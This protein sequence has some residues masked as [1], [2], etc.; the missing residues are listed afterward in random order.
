VCDE[1]PCL[2]PSTALREWQRLP[3]GLLEAVIEARAYGRLKAAYDAATTTEA[4]AALP[5]SPL[6]DL[7]KVIT[8][9]RAQAEIDEGKGSAIGD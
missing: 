7:V 2:S 8:F 1:F 3:V 9:E 4:R 5:A 6:L